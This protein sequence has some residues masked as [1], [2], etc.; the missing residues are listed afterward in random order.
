M[1][2]LVKLINSNDMKPGS[3]VYIITDSAINDGNLFN[4]RIFDLI[5][6]KHLIIHTIIIGD[7]LPP[8]GSKK[9]YRDKT[10]RP[11]LDFAYTTGGGF[12]Q[13]SDANNLPTFWTNQMASFYNSISLTHSIYFKC[14]ERIDFFQVRVFDLLQIEHGCVSRSAV[15][16]LPS[17]LICSRPRI[18]VLQLLARTMCGKF[19]A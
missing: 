12:Y 19:L 2:A 8:G 1:T 10:V 16:T 9:K 14:T 6:Q 4:E 3:P 18:N 17:L 15:K 5:A 11:Y 7:I 13:V